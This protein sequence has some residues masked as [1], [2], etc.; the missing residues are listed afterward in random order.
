MGCVATKNVAHPTTLAL[1]K[2]SLMDSVST[3]NSASSSEFEMEIEVDDIFE[4]DMADI[5]S[6]RRPK[7][8]PADPQFQSELAALRQ[9]YKWEDI[10][11]D[12]FIDENVEESDSPGSRA[13][14]RI[15]GRRNSPSFV[16]G[17]LPKNPRKV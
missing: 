1:H 2:D 7:R 17:K 9:F 4:E 10:P 8:S 6:R 15:S 3:A 16:R 5:S 13:S 12:F 11:M 14:R